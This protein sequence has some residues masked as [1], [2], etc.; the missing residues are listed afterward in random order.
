MGDREKREIE[1]QQEGSPKQKLVMLVEKQELIKKMLA[2]DDER[3]LKFIGDFGD[4]NDV[5]VGDEDP[6]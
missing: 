5:P 3:V 4:L 1:P 6:S 2:E